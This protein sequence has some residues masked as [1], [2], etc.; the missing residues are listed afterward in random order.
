[1]KQ[2]AVVLAGYRAAFGLLTLS[3]IVAQAVDTA[4]RGVLN[5]TNF[6]SF[7]TIQCNLFGAVVFLVVAMRGTKPRWGSIDAMRGASVA[8]LIVV[9]VVFALLLSHTDVGLV[10]PWVDTVTHKIFPVVVLA[11]WL[12][13]PP[14]RPMN[15]R[16]GVAWTAYPLLYACYSL[17][18]G[19]LTGWYAY[20]FFNPANGGYGTVAAYVGGIVVLQLVACAAVIWL[21]NVRRAGRFSN[22]H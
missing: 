12:I 17:I 10:I 18:R 5:P 13:D 7:F 4:D 11:D 19:H 15:V 6:L 14:K 8:Y 2:R 9:F 20:P 16:H 21:G 1:M 3:A 22:P